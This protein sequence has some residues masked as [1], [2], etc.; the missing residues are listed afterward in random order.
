MPAL[1]QSVR[2]EEHG[3]HDTLQCLYLDPH[4]PVIRSLAVSDGDVAGELG[5][6]MSQDARDRNEASRNKAKHHR[7]PW[8]EYELEFLVVLW[9]GTEQTLTEIAEELGRTI[10][11]CRQRWYE[12]KWG[13]PIHRP[14]P[15]P[16]HESGWLVGYCTNCGRF[17]DVWCDGTAIRL[18]DDCR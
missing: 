8:E 16:L 15:A 17:T 14:A 10:E 1:V 2:A 6:A 18:C 4:H 7:E 11:A 3:D 12:N 9:D 13:E 5:N